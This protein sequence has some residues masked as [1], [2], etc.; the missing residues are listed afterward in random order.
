MTQR[1]GQDFADEVATQIRDD[2]LREFGQRHL[3]NE[4][5]R[6]LENPQAD[7]APHQERGRS[8]GTIQNRVDQRNQTSVAGATQQCS[9]CCQ[10]DQAARGA[11]QK[12]QQCHRALASNPS[13]FAWR[14]LFFSSSANT[15]TCGSSR[16]LSWAPGTILTVTPPS[17]SSPQ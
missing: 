17:A 15:A 12:S 3:G 2:V 11:K 16:M 14:R 5:S 7:K 6:Q 1:H 13:A 8:A 4:I 9:Q 10:Q